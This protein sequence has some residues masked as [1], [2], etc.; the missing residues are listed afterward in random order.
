MTTQLY[1]YQ[2]YLYEIEWLDKESQIDVILGITTNV[3]NKILVCGWRFEH[4]KHHYE[5][6]T[7]NIFS[8]ISSDTEANAS[9][10]LQNLEKCLFVTDSSVWIMNKRLYGICN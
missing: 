6:G 3:S 10:L 5:C 1:H 7:E 2:K 9:E 8:G 4:A